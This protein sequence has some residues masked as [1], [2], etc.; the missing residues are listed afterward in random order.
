MK[1]FLETNCVE[2]SRSLSDEWLKGICAFANSVGVVLCI[3]ID[4][5]KVDAR[6]GMIVR[7]KAA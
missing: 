5:K 1:R 7:G 3:G 2:F 6:N 4:E